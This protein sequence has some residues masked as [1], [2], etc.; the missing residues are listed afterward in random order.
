MV[1]PG[2]DTSLEVL[3]LE[4]PCHVCAAVRCVADEASL[5]ERASISAS[6]LK[7]EDNENGF[8]SKLSTK[9]FEVV[10][11]W[12]SVNEINV[13]SFDLGNGPTEGFVSDSSKGRYDLWTD[14]AL[15]Y[16]PF[17]SFS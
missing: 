15:V 5:A 14:V 16:H 8:N 3:E 10:F 13:G 7:V 12:S 4:L 2:L 17:F 11:S 6:R 9:S 1:D